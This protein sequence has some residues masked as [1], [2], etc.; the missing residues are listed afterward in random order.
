MK[1]LGLY[2]HIPFCRSKCRYCDFCSFPTHSAETMT[3][4]VERLC[5]DLAARSEDCRDYTVD[6]VYLGGGNANHSPG[7][8][9][10]PD[11]GSRPSELPRF[12]RLRIHGGM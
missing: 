8:S 5:A 7:G 10:C 1:P 2:L 11:R 9:A 12:A 3:A 6:S 4:Y